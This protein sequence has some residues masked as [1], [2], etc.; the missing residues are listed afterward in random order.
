MKKVL[1]ILILCA[2]MLGGIS[3]IGTA[4][5]GSGVAVMANE[6]QVIKSGLL[7][8]KLRISDADFKCAFAI[9]DF[10]SITVTR[11]PSSTEG[12]LLLAGRRVSEGQTVSRRS[13]NAMLFVP[14]SREITESGFSFTIKGGPDGEFEFKMRFLE[15]VNY[16]PQ[17]P[18]DS[19]A[20]LNLVTQEGISV[21][22]RMSATDPEGDRIEYIIVRFPEYGRIS[23]GE[24][25]EYKYTPTSGHKGYDSFVYVA[26]DEYGNYTEPVNVEIKTTERLSSQVFTDMTDRPEYNAAVALSAMGIMGGSPV[27]DEYCFNPDGS[28]SKAEFVAMSMKAM[29]IRPD[30]ALTATYFDD[31]GS[32]PKSLVGYVATA[33]RMGII[34]G[35]F[36]KDGLLFN[37]NDQINVYQAAMIISRVKGVERD[38]EQTVYTENETVPIWAMS[39]VCAMYTLGIFDGEPEE[40]DG[41]AKISRADCAE[42]LYRMIKA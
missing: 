18:K 36:G 13:V 35:E 27:G 41:S 15:K 39:D 16:A 23:V 20:S 14:L 34:D 19:T 17:T 10:D 40:L 28:V 1:A 37:P 31:N 24:K 32:I 8:Q 4:A 3:A 11:L 21:F 2:I 7:G 38:D 9:A 12:T 25:G 6:V 5:L 29:G 42:Y 22:G 26:R 30:N 33:Q